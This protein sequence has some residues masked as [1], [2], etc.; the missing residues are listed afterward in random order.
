VACMEAVPGMAKADTARRR[1][2]LRLHGELDA[3]NEDVLIAALAAVLAA[4]PRVLIVDMTE[5]SYID[6]RCL[7][8]LARS[9]RPDGGRVRVELRGVRPLVRRLLALTGLDESRWRRHAA[10]SGKPPGALLPGTGARVRSHRRP[11]AGIIP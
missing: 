10:R 3:S 2:V 11:R 4:G 9:R 6:C 1:P 5:L 8:I 7:S